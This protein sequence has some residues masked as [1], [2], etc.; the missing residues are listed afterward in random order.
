LL[1]TDGNSSLV[2]TYRWGRR[3]TSLL[4]TNVIHRKQS[5]ERAHHQ[6]VGYAVGQVSDGSIWNYGRHRSAADKFG[7]HALD[8]KVHNW[9]ESDRVVMVYEQ[10]DNSGHYW[11]HYEGRVAKP[12]GIFNHI[13]ERELVDSLPLC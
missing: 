6:L 9:D 2:H 12:E 11:G 5:I 8:S 7:D 3:N 4:E 13:E 10:S 1:R